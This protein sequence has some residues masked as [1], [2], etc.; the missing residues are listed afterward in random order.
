MT[1]WGTH[2]SAAFTLNFNLRFWKTWTQWNIVRVLAQHVQCIRK[3]VEAFTLCQD[4]SIE[5]QLQDGVQVLD[6][7]IAVHQQTFYVSHTFAC[8]RLHDVLRTLKQFLNTQG[9]LQLH[10][11]V[12][13]DYEARTTLDGHEQKLLQ[14]LHVTLGGDERVSV[15][16]TPRNKSLVF[17]ATVHDGRQLDVVWLQAST[18]KAFQQKLQHVTWRPNTVLYWCLTPDT[19]SIKHRDSIKS[20]TQALMVQT[21]PVRTV[22]QIKPQPKM[23]LVDFWNKSRS[24]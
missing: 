17:P 15:W 24:E 5:Q 22:A 2:N 20:M 16:Y 19:Q 1:L 11:L 3:R 8:R 4:M 7:R 6:L 18:V 9:E 12:K 23:V 14:C 13:P 10:V 21:D